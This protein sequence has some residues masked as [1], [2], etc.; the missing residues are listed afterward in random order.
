MSEATRGDNLMF[1]YTYT[2]Y[3]CTCSSSFIMPRWAEPERHMVVIVF[4]CCVL[5][6]STISSATANKLS[7]DS[8]KATI[9]T[10]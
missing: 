7:N 3:T 4:V 8:C 2:V 9:T 6:C 1:N 5:F 10:T